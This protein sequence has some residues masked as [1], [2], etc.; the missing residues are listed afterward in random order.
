MTWKK[1]T[2]GGGGWV[3]SAVGSRTSWVVPVPVVLVVVVFSSFCTQ[4]CW[5]M[6]HYMLKSAASKCFK[7]DVTSDMVLLVDFEAPDIG[8]SEEAPPGADGDEPKLGEEGLD[9]RYNQRERHKVCVR[10]QIHVLQPCGRI[11]ILYLFI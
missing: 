1:T 11:I 4:T 2:R 3:T 7:V 8:L 6:H 9:S 10:V 5:A